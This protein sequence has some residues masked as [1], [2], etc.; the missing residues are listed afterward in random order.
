MKLPRDQ[1]AVVKGTGVPGP[2]AHDAHA[3]ERSVDGLLVGEIALVV[4]NLKGLGLFG[5]DFE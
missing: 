3:A 2:L 4:N 1:E 5:G